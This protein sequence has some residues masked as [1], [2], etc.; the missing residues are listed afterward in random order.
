MR[1]AGKITNW[2]DDQG[3]GFITPNNGGPQ[4]FVHVKAFTNKNRRPVGNESVTYELATDS[5]GRT[6]AEM[7]ARAGEGLPNAQWGKRGNF[8]SAFA[9]LFLILLAGLTITGRLPIVVPGL[10][11]IAS[12]VA[13]VAYA[14]DK[15]AAKN[16]RWRTSEST[17]HLYGLVGGWPGALMAQ[18][19][20][21]HKSSKR[22]FQMAFWVTVFLNN[23]VLIWL[24]LPQGSEFLHSKFLDSMWLQ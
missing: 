2:K 18:K 21:R 8:A 24:I 17:L 7:V 20:L 4:V 13:F 9:V 23:M 22:S 16:D 10:Y 5:S 19:L 3:Y 11:L 14:L 1:H 6:R 15:S 12:I